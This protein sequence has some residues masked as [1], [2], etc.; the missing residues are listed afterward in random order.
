MS[1]IETS[2]FPEQSQRPSRGNNTCLIVGGIGCLAIVFLVIIVAAL[3][4]SGTKTVVS[5]LVEQFTD[6]APAP[7]PDVALAPEE[8]DSAV[9]RW[10][11]FKNALLQNQPAPTLVLTSNDVNALIRNHPDWAMV[12]DQAYVSVE[13]DKLQAQLSVSLEPFATIPLFGK[14]VK[15]RYF[16]GKA[17][18][19]V[20]VRNGMLFVTVEGAEV[21]GRALPPEAIAE[22]RQKNIAEDVR[23]NPNIA[24]IL[25]RVERLEVADGKITIIPKNRAD[26]INAP[27]AS[28]QQP[29]QEPAP[30]AAEPVSA[31]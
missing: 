13:G 12:K 15:G 16:N 2:R 28:E 22:L 27:G 6:V 7:M 14:Y 3:L 4:Y 23:Q 8:I 10:N 1:D 18:M 31:S 21:K 25:D 30:S 29:V 26:L 20:F 11:E 5:T 17:T 9:Q 19:D 24:A